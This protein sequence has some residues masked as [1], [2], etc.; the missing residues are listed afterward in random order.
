[1]I[2]NKDEESVDQH[3]HQFDFEKFVEEANTR[4]KKR[5]ERKYLM[6]V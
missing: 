1:M 6:I 2:N 4:L 5:E 3:S